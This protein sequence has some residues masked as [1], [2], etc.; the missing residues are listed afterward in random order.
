MSVRIEHSGHVTTVIMDRVGAR[1]AVDE[2][3]AEA[4]MQAFVA[5]EANPDA[6]AAVLWGAG[7]TFCAGYDLKYASTL[8]DPDAFRREFIDKLPFP[9]EDTSVRGPMGPSRLALSKPVIA[10]VE[11]A[12]VAGGMELALWC[13]LRVMA[14]DA[15]FGVYCRRWGIPLIDGGTVRLPRLIGLGRAMDLI[16]TGRKVTAEESLRIGLCDRVVARGM[17]RPAAEDLA[18]EIARFPQ[19]ALKADRQSAYDSLGLDV[20]EAMI[21]E[22]TGGVESFAT[23]GAAG[24]GRFA[25]GRGR[26]GDFAN[27]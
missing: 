1:N 20:R 8:A 15:F 19:A 2:P 24:A 7:G 14:E 5:F 10:A 9:S 26:S 4:L 6:R 21:R 23:E 11:G 25:Q 22:W 18:Q 13:D 16:L 12:S 17:A 3:T 27:I